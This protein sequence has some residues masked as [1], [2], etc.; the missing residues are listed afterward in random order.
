MRIEFRVPVVVR[1][2]PKRTKDVKL[3]IATV[4]RV[5]DVPEYS[6]DD[7]PVVLSGFFHGDDDD[8]G[9][10]I[11]RE[12]R[13]IDGE[14]F[15]DVDVDCEG[16]I[17]PSAVMERDE[18]VP[19]PF[20]GVDKVFWSVFRGMQ[21][22]T[23]RSVVYPGDKVSEV[24]DGRM[25]VL[26]DLSDLGVA[27]VDQE[28]L[29]RFVSAFDR[30]A[31][32]LILVDGRV[33]LRERAPALEVVCNVFTHG[34]KTFVRAT[35][36]VGDDP[37][38]KYN[39]EDRHENP[40][41]FFQIDQLEE[42]H[43]F[44]SSLGY[45]VNGDDAVDVTVEEDAAVYFDSPSATVN[46]IAVVMNDHISG[47]MDFGIDRRGREFMNRL[48]VGVMHAYRRFEAILPGLDEE[49]VPEELADLVESVLALPEQEKKL[50]LPDEP[51]AESRIRAAMQLW[52]DRPVEFSFS[53][54]PNR[55]KRKTN[56]GFG[57]IGPG[58]PF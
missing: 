38:V 52:H 20:Q 22:K 40:V 44:A 46:A 3:V 8:H 24:V 18:R 17:S 51:N 55:F 1:A 48:T 25:T 30:E 12:F 32:K 16:V 41:A 4:N 43:A 42:A 37:L 27:D 28:M 15:V 58:M 36:R 11:H 45:K 26:H 21:P 14:L 29:G 2:K 7:A 34:G 10:P 57:M 19:M 9:H 31:S 54:A 39:D 6:S 47:S 49:A 53:P 13:E 33:H 35:R 23:I 50:F 5:V 56:R